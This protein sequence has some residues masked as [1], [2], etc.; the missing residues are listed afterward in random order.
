MS[1]KLTKTCYSKRLTN[2]DTQLSTI[3]SFIK[4]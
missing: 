1:A 2:E 4:P 3:V